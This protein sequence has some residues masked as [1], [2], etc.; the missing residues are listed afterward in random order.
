MKSIQNSLSR[1][2]RSLWLA[3]GV[4]VIFVVLFAIY[5][6]AEKQIDR[7]NELRFQS[8]RLADELRQSS[9]DLTRMVRTY[10]ITGNPIY[11]QHSGNSRHSQRQAAA[12]GQLRR[13]LLGSGHG[14]RP[15]PD[16][17]R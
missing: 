13:H 3:L 8:Y 6:L 17:E 11:K 15:A 2:S 16:S 1:F 7:A 9:D 10:V 14:R 12:P 4:C 5:V